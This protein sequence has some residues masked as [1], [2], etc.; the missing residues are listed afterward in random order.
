MVNDATGKGE[1]LQPEAQQNLCCTLQMKYIKSK[2]FFKIDAI[3]LA[4][5]IKI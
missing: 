5:E 3:N 2:F 1:I 4:I